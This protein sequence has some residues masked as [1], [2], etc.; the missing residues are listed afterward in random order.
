MRIVQA[1]G[2]YFSE[3]IGGTDVYVAGLSRRL[4]EA[5]IIR[6]PTRHISTMA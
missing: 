6:R 5:E 2:W 4:C 1:L 3:S